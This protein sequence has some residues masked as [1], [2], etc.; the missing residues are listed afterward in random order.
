MKVIL[1]QNVKNIGKAGEIKEVSDGFARNFLF[2]KKKAEIATS[3]AVAQ[4][5]QTKQ[6]NIKKETEERIRLEK[7][8]ENLKGKKIT[9]IAK[10]EKGKLFGSITAK[11]IVQELKKGEFDIR[12]SSIILQKALRELGE[13]EVE[14][15]LGKNIKTKI[16]VSIQEK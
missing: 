6:E 14:I 15:D 12:E 13:K 7:I 4:A 10:A 8:A 2:P 1:L 9:I 3:E 16:L 5:E 11:D